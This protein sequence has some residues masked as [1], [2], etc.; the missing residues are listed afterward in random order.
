MSYKRI[1]T[2]LTQEQFERFILPHLS[3]GKRGPK[4]NLSLHAIFNYILSVIYTGMQWQNISIEQDESGTPKMHY[5]RIFRIYQRWVH[6]GSLK[7]VFEHSVIE[8][9]QHGLLDFSIL[10]GDGSLT[11]AKKGGDVIGYSGHKHFKGEKIVAIVDRNVNV[12]TPFTTVPANKHESPLFSDALMHLKNI[13]GKIGSVI[14]GTI[15]SLDSAYDS[16]KNRKMIFNA[17][18]TPNI[19]ENKRNRKHNKRGPKRIY[20][21][22]IF[23]ERF[24][25]IERL[26]AW[27]DKFKRL[28]LR[29][30]RHHQ[31]HFGMKLIAYTMIN[32]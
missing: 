4:P 3:Q 2:S 8:L 5:T 23:Q 19:P 32:L 24:R 22:H 15:M 9:E 14:K 27:E 6:D 26:F 18:M 12:L 13:V 10:H 21:E 1:P 11:T 7:Q 17:G 29:F 31:H 25:T 16:Q 30:E 20:D 28:L